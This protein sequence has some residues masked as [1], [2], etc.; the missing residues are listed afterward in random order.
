[1]RRAILAFT[2]LLLTGTAAAHAAH[3]EGTDEIAYQ[4]STV[5]EILDDTGTFISTYN[6]N[7]EQLPSLVKSLVSG[8]KA[9]IHIETA[10]GEKVIGVAMDGAK[11]ASVEQGGLDEPTVSIHTDASTL[12]VIATA[13]NP[14]KE[15]MAAFN[16][17]A[18]TYKTHGL[19]TTIKFAVLSTLSGV[20]GAVL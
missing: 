18:I 9:N 13:E 17:P 19:G 12:E 6:S 20:I 8:E 11:I 15:A 16:G 5:A 4:N 1:M 10:E 14:R 7:A 3:F 2:V